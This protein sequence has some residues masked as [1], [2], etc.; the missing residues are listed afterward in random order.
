MITSY[1]RSLKDAG[2]PDVNDMYEL[3]LKAWNGMLPDGH[4]M[5]LEFKRANAQELI[6]FLESID[7]I[8]NERELA[9]DNILF[10]EDERLWGALINGRC[11]HEVGERLMRTE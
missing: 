2:Q 6:I 8:V 5:S 9:D 11:W 4:E 3:Y 10:S 1:F 7:T